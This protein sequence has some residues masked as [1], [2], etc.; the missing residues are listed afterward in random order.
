MNLRISQ[1]QATRSTFTF[2]RVTHFMVLLLLLRARAQCLEPAER[3][4]NP[5]QM[6]MLAAAH[7][8]VFFALQG[9][10]ISLPC[11]VNGELFTIRNACRLDHIHGPFESASWVERCLTGMHLIIHG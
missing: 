2:S 8:F 9:P 11:F 4:L 5:L 6:G 10:L 7:P 1:G 3:L